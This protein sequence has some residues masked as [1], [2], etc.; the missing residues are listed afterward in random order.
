[1]F[2]KLALNTHVAQQLSWEAQQLEQ[3]SAI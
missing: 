2:E 3:L 1:L